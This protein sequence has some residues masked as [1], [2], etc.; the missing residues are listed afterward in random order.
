MVQSDH[1]ADP[2]A[3]FVLHG[4]LVRLSADGYLIPSDCWLEVGQRW[5]SLL[6]GEPPKEP[7]WLQPLKPSSERIRPG[8]STDGRLLLVAGIATTD[9]D[10]SHA[11]AG[12]EAALEEA[13]AQWAGGTGGKHRDRPLLAMPLIGTGRGGMKDRRGAIVAKVIKALDARLPTL[14]FDVALVAYSRADYAAIQHA[15][16]TSGAGVAVLPDPLGSRVE[17]LAGKAR[18]GGLAVLFG[19]GVSMPL[20]LPSWRGL[21]DSLGEGLDLQGLADLDPTDAA[22]LLAER[23]GSDFVPKLQDLLALRRHSLAHGLLAS[24]RPV[25]AVTTNYDRGYELAMAQVV[26]ADGVSV[27]PWEPPAR[28]TAPRVLK[29]HGDVEHGSIVLTR[30]EFVQMHATRRPLTGLLQEQLLAGHVLAIGTTMS[31]STLTLA[32]AEAVALTRSVRRPQSSLGTVVLT[33][34]HPGRRALLAGPF[35]VVAADEGLAGAGMDE[36][37][38][39]LAAAR[40]VD[41]MLDRIAMEASTD[42]SYLADPAYADLIADGSGWRYIAKRAR[43]LRR[44]IE[45]HAPADPTWDAL[46]VALD[47]VGATAATP[48]SA[49]RVS[50]SR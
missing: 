23:R 29:L 15:R 33:E 40:R 47:G 1:V 48:G 6:G 16:R 32:V 36:Q 35:D 7:T 41:L 45:E 8:R 9:G 20:G 26:G 43:E 31:D 27:L 19:A 28:V 3:L 5:Q 14:S 39:L 22:A 34:D 10:Q 24:L 18:A 4:D 11:I 46:R 25:V 21:L 2:S 38:R 37:G 13:A 12:L 17:N 42:T 50:D 30:D 49:T 44:V